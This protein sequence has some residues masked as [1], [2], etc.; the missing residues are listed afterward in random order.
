MVEIKPNKSNFLTGSLYYMQ[1]N[2]TKTQMQ[3]HWPI[4][5]KGFVCVCA[6]W[7]AQLIFAGDGGGWEDCTFLTF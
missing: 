1:I 5:F 7:G 6:G 3:A 2:T 4:H